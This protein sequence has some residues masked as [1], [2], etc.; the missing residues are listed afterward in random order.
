MEDESSITDGWS[1]ALRKP[2]DSVTYSQGWTDWTTDEW[3]IYKTHSTPGLLDIFKTPRERNVT[4]RAERDDEGGGGVGW[5]MAR[6]RPYCRLHPRMSHL[7]RALSSLLH[8]S[9]A[10]VDQLLFT[11]LSY[12]S[13]LE[14]L[15]TNIFVYNNVCAERSLDTLVSVE[16]RNIYF[17]ECVCCWLCVRYLWLIQRSMRISK[18]I[19][20]VY[21][22]LLLLFYTFLTCEE[23]NY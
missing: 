6:C 20:Y 19:A 22:K 8:G 18:V 11:P 4:W 9:P 23:V 17:Y 21:I 13:P 3:N 2:L 14:P 12:R 16:W 15:P 1:V 10:I 7:S 5:H